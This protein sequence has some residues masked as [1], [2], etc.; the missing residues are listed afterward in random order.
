[1]L[2]KVVIYNAVSLD[3]NIN[4]GSVDMEKFYGLV[5]VW[6]EDATLSGSETILKGNGQIPHERREDFKPWRVE[7]GDKRALLVVPDSR[8]RI[9]IWH[10][11]RRSGYWRD[12]MALC[13][14]STPVSYLK[15]LRKRHINCIVTGGMKV[16]LMAALETLRTEFGI[17]TVR[18]DSGGILNGVL[19][20]QGLVNEVSVLIHPELA[21]DNAPKHFYSGPALPGESCRLRL[22]GV[23]K[24]KGGLVW[25]RYRVIH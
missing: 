19:L 16:D 1:M 23:Q 11:L 3:G 10:Y 2:P 6:K 14:R 20:R 4:I 15:Y 9:R 21:G 8:G 25:L 7:P 13:S 12:V 5:G 22:F 18:S 24:V 17:R